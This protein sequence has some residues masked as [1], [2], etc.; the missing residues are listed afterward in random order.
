MRLLALVV[1]TVTSAS[2]QFLPAGGQT[3]TL[4]TPD[5]VRQYV[6]EFGNAQAAG[7][8]VVVL[9]G[10]FGA[11]HSY[12]IDP[13][14]PLADRYHFI[15]YDQ[16]GSVLSPVEDDSLLT[17]DAMVSDLEALRVQLGLRHLTL[18]AHSMGAT[19]S[20]G[21][22]DRHPER[23]RGLALLAPALP[24]LGSFEEPPTD[25]RLVPPA[26]SA[27]ARE[28]FRRYN[29]DAERRLAVVLEAEGFPDPDTLTTEQVMTTP[30]IQ[31]AL[32][33][34]YRAGT[35][36]YNTCHPERW[37]QFRGVGRAFYRQQVAD[38]IFADANMPALE[39]AWS[40]MIPALEA[41]PGPVAYVIGDCDY[42]DPEAA[43]TP[44]L[45]ARL[46]NSRVRVLRDAGHIFW[47]DDPAAAT[48]AIEDALA[49][50]TGRVVRR[51]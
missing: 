21:Y 25:P 4:V 41:F 30:G 14:L 5:G 49:H 11:E 24:D 12:L 19:I 26:D 38:A 6:M 7:D 28:R 43:M 36:A 42:L 32:F 8:T 16:R 18:M 45:A 47:I 37:R 31:K 34:R 20:Y 50:A 15:L 48:A 33:S 44:R 13:L 10:G 17:F 40:R 3:W 35:A 9:H 2:A 23:V 27:A 1:L 51:S 39:A 29:E 46:P 22:L